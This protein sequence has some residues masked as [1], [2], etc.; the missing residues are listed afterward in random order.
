ME[1]SGKDTARNQQDHDSRQAVWPHPGDSGSQA[2]WPHRHLYPANKMHSDHHPTRKFR[3]QSLYKF[4]K[5][6][7]YIFKM[8]E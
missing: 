7:V 3:L 5:F 1:E 2:T 6:T 4:R 8:I